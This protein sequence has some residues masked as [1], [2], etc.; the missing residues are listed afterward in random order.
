[1]AVKRRNTS[2]RSLASKHAREN[3][4][5]LVMFSSRIEEPLADY[6]KVFTSTRAVTKQDV[7]REALLLFKQKQ[8]SLQKA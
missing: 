7:L 5:E 6:V 4:T 3:N 2:P 8:E 1:M